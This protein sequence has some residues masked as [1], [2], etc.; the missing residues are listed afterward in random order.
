[1]K[2][3]QL[4]EMSVEGLVDRFA[5]ICID[6]DQAL[7]Y[8]ELAKFNRLYAQMRAIEEELKARQ[9]DQRRALL[10][11]Y[12]HPNA[13]VRLQAAGATLAVA[14]DMARRL[15]ES[16]ASSRKYPQAGDA[17]MTLDNLDRGIF[18]PT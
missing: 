17:G 3:A 13:Q 1:M 6:Q 11:L 5:A 10:N 12:T 8:S 15:I 7:L 2:P 4:K 18:K 16:I 9:G 14:P